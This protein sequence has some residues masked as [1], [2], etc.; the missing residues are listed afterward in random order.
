LENSE[1]AHR[2]SKISRI[3]KI[4][5]GFDNTLS[6]TQYIE[7]LRYKIKDLLIDKQL[8][9]GFFEFFCRGGKMK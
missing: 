2:K 4:L 7:L 6:S 3:V 5:E 9:S 1:L 8:C